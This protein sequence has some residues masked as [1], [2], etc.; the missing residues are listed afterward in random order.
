MRYE[1]K[2]LVEHVIGDGK[3]PTSGMK[4]GFPLV[5]L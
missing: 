4:I 3:T 5:L 1:A 2:P